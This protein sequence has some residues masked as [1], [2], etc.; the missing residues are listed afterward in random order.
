MRRKIGILVVFVMVLIA[1]FGVTAFATTEAPAETVETVFE[2]KYSSDSVY[3]AGITCEPYVEPGTLAVGFEI[4]KDLPVGYAIYDAGDTPYIDG[5]RI[6][7]ET[8]ESLKVL[9]TEGVTTYTVDVKIVY[10]EG[11]LGDL[12]SMSDG[13]Y[14]WAKL[15][16]N[17]IILLQGI[18]FVLATLSIVVG[19]VATLFG[20]G[21]KVK[22][23]DEIANKVAESSEIAIA[24]VE[25]RVTDAVIDEVIPIVEKILDSTQ[26]VVKAITLSTSKSKDAPIALLDTLRDSANVNTAELIDTIKNTLQNALNQESAVHEERAKELHEIA[27][28]T[29]AEPVKPSIT[30]ST[31][32]KSIF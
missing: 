20:K 31:T 26:N 10:V 18:Y 25:K 6:N 12:A 15:L 22:T 13:T 14:D 4:V 2:V 30:E 23:A 17:P 7:G 9:L 28:A 3:F 24:N 32:E 16:E 19:L 11:I 5:I 21:K 29:P 8:T 1:V 27:N